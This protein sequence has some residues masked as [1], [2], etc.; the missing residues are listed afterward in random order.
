MYINQ[1]GVTRIVLE[2]ENTVVKI[3][4]FRYCWDH[5]LRGILANISEHK[6]WRF[7][8]KD[9][10]LLCPVLWCSWGGWILVMKKARVLTDREFI[11]HVDIGLYSKAG[12][13]GDD[14]SDNYGWLDN[15]CVKI[16]YGHL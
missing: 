1:K 6:R 16:D 5:F 4:N 13:D 9:R 2:F 12:L 11:E 8:K 10:H 7:C 14:T 15:R 3:P